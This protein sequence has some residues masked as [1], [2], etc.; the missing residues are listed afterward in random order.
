MS[1]SVK[2]ARAW[3][4]LAA[5]MTMLPKIGVSKPN[6]ILHMGLSTKLCAIYVQA[7]EV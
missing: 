4:I 5:E 6:L 1:R 7:K 2:T 3:M